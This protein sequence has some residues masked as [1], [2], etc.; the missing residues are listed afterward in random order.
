MRP[1]SKRIEVV[2]LSFKGKGKRCSGL[3]RSRISHVVRRSNQG[4]SDQSNIEILFLF[5]VCRR[6]RSASIGSKTQIGSS[7]WPFSSFF[8]L[9]P[10]LLVKKRC[11]CVFFKAYPGA[12]ALGHPIPLL[13]FPEDLTSRAASSCSGSDLPQIPRNRSG[14]YPLLVSQF[15]CLS[16]P[17][18]IYIY[19]LFPRGERKLQDEYVLPGFPNSFSS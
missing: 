17:L 13:S 4:F 19:K 12:A 1:L 10:A 3:P 11:V 7:S 9:C 14:G 5:L 15:H 2:L 18:E 8:C 16:S 6:A